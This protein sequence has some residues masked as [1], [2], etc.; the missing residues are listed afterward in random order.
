MKTV[1][2]ATY[3]TLA[4][5]ALA[6]LIQDKY[7]LDNVQCKL[8]VRGV[9]DTY[10]ITTPN[11]KFILRAY[12][13]SHRS[14][15]QIQE[16]VALLKTLQQAQVSV[17]YPIPDNAGNMI[18][19]LDAIEGER[20]IV[21]FSFAPGQVERIMSTAQLRSL[22]HEMARF[23]QIAI[24]IRPNSSRWN[25][26]LQTTLFKPLEMLAP[27]FSEDTET[28]TWLQEKATQAA[29]KLSTFNTTD[30]SSGYCHFDFLPK[31]FHFE[32]DRVTLF[33]FDFMG[34][35]WMV[36]DIMTFWQHLQLDVYLGKRL[37]R[38]AADEAFATFLNAY[39]EIRPVSEAE[40]AAIPYL[41]LG[42]WLFYKGFHTTHDQFHF[43]N[44]P[45][46]F[47]PILLYLKTMIDN[48]WQQ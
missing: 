9:G 40:L 30:F 36:N 29:D 19:Q 23:H 35:G 41:S 20:Y 11:D 18:Q 45:S 38:E 16:E 42:F 44:E 8:L 39:R 12:R 37:T 6:S 15:P 26:D 14:F 33:D 13:S 17:S 24:D 2:P 48:H 4:P 10:L 25:F 3:S 34:Y 21:L 46:Y 32:N 5:G 1:F 31:N 47:K 27:V 43:F 7:P 22:G 28:Y